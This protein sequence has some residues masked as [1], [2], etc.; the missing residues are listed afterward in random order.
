MADT[1]DKLKFV[2]PGLNSP[3]V[4]PVTAVVVLH[5]TGATIQHWPHAA[6]TRAGLWSWDRLP[7]WCRDTA[8]HRLRPPDNDL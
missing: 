4:S 5:A 6:G 2:G 8:L 3:A 1:N 7:Q